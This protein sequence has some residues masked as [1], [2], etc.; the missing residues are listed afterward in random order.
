MTM[1][2]SD[3]EQKDLGKQ[4]VFGMSAVAKPTPLWMKYI[5][6]GFAFLSGVW[7]LLPQDLLNIDANAM[8]DISR[9]IIVS[10][11]IML[12]AIKFFGW[13]YKQQ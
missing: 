3:K 13:D 8:A 2:I 7:A 6:R 4:V 1:P 10:N 5:F 11:T 12:F 9:W